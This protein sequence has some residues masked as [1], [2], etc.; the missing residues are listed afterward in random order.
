METEAS[1]QKVD[2]KL[3]SRQVSSCGCTFGL[4]IDVC[5]KKFQL[6]TTAS[7]IP[8]YTKSIEGHKRDVL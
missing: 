4:D 1:A 6:S 2:E 5:G 7:G 8:I 3:Y